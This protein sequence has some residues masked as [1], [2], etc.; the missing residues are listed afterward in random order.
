MFNLEVRTAI[1]LQLYESEI[2]RRAAFNG[3]EMAWALVYRDANGPMRRLFA[4][5]GR[6]FAAALQPR[7]EKPVR[8]LHQPVTT[9]LHLA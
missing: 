8:V 9:S 5:I 2:A 4:F 7:N 1:Q 3:D 6:L